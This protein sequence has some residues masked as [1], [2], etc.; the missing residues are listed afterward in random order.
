[1]L[2]H[3]NEL[4]QA[5]EHAAMSVALS[6]KWDDRWLLSAHLSL[7]G[8]Y[9]LEQGDVDQAAAAYVEAAAIAGAIASQDCLGKAS[10][11]LARVALARG[12]RATATQ[13]AQIAAT[14]LRSSGHRA[15][16]VLDTWRRQVR[17]GNRS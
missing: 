1:L 3:V 6:R 7:W 13:E 15:A 17:L 10:F 2:A 8:G 16:A 9:A 11:G 12:D 4:D 5:A 14:L